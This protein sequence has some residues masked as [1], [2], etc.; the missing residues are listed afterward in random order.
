MTPKT[1][2]PSSQPTVTSIHLDYDDG[3]SDD[4]KLLQSGERP[5]YDLRR[6]RP[7]AEARSMGAHT[8]GAIASILFHTVTTTERIEYSLKD[9]LIRAVMAKLFGRTPES[10]KALDSHN[11]GTEVNTGG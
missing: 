10:E 3:S 2:P 5:A 6:Q 4:I 7:G 11:E 8:A 9:P 1:P